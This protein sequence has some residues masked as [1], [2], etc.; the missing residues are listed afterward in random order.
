MFAKI[1]PITLL[2]VLVGCKGCQ[3][4][5]KETG[6]PIGETGDTDHTGDTGETGVLDEDG[7]GIPA[8][9]DCDDSDPM[10]GTG[11]TWYRD[12]DGDGYGGG[13]ET[14]TAC[15][16]PEGYAATGDDCD[17]ND[18]YYHPGATEDDCLDPNDYNCDGSVGYADLDGDGVPACED[19]DDSN[20]GANPDA[21]ET[22]D[23]VD[24]D[25]DSEIDEEATDASTWYTD[26]DADGYGVDE[27]A[28]TS[29]TQPEGTAAVTGD[30]DDADAAYNPG[31]TEDD[32]S[33]PNDYNC[34]G[35]VGYTDADGDGWAAC[36]EC[37]DADASE[38]PDVVEICDG[39]DDDCDGEIDEDDAYDASTWYADSDGDTYG[40]P[41]VSETSCLAPDGYVSDNTDCDDLS[42]T[43]F[44]G[45]AEECDGEDND[46]DEEIDE[47][48]TDATDWYADADGDTYGDASVSVSSCDPGDGYSADNTDCDDTNSTEYPGADEICD[49]DDDDC[50]GEIDEDDATDAST[51][52]ADGD[53]DGYGD[54]A[55]TT[56]S[57]STPDG[58][59]AY[60]GDCDDA[61]PAY[62]P[63]ATE[64]DC[65]DPNDY[66]CDGSVG[67]VDEDGDGFAACEECDDADAS[68]NPDGT[69]VCDDIDN[70]C[71]GSIDE[72]GAGGAGTWYA[73][74]DGDGYGDP[75]STVESCEAPEGYVADATD[76]DDTD[77]D[78]HPDGAEYC[79]GVDDDCDGETDEDAAF[80]ASTWYA[81]TDSD[82]YGDAGSTVSACS[83]PDGYVDDDTDCDDADADSHPDALEYCDDADNDCDGETDEDAEDA[84]KY[85]QDAD[86]DTY[87]DASV[88]T[89]AC[90]RPS[91]SWR[92][93]SGDCDD[94][95]SSINPAA[96]EVC[97]GEDNDCDGSI[98]EAGSSGSTTWHA[99][100]DGDG[101]GDPYVSE[102]SCEAPAGY[103]DDETDCD[104]DDA[105]INPAA[106]EICDGID[107]D[108][109]GSVDDGA[110]DSAT[111]YA[112]EDGD[113][114]GDASDSV[115]SCDAPSGYVSDDQDCDD[116]DGS[117]NPD[118]D[119]VCDGDDDDCDGSIDESDAIDES[120]W[121]YDGDDDGYG[122]D[123]TTRTSCDAP[124]GYVG[125]GGDC[126]DADPAYNPGAT[127]DDCTDPNDY[128]CDGSTGYANA[129]GDDY[130]ACEDCDDTDASEYPGANEICD[131]DDD[132]CDGRTDESDAV[133]ESTWYDDDDGD[134][135]G[136]PADSR[137]ACDAPTG[138]VADDEDCDD[139]DGTV[140]P[141]AAERCDDQDND[142][143]GTVDEGASD[144]STW[145]ADDDSD[146][147]GDADAS[148]TSCDAPT[149]YVSDDQDCDDSDPDENPDADEVCDG[150]DD[151]CDGNVDEASAVDASTWYADDDSDGYGDPSTTRRACD[152][153]SGYT[154]DDQDCDDT[155]AEV[156]PGERERC[157]D[158][159]DDCDG[160]IDESDAIDADTWYSDLDD[161][162]YGDPDSTTISCTTPD[163]AVGNDDDCDDGRADVNPGEDEVCD[164]R[165]NDCD[166]LVDEDAVD[167]ETWY[168]EDADDDGYG[169]D[170]SMVVD[171][172]APSG[173]VSL[174]GDCDD[175]DPTLNPGETDLCD[176]VDNDCDGELDE[177]VV[178]GR[179]LMSGDTS[180]DAVLSINPDDASAVEI[181]SLTTSTPISSVAVGP[182]GTAFVHNA[183]ILYSFDP[184]TG[185]LTEI[186]ASGRGTICG[187][188]FD[189]S[190]T[191][192]GLDRTSRTLVTFDT[193]TGAGT[194]VGALG[195]RIAACGMAYDCTTDRLVAADASTNS[196]FTIDP[197]SGA[198]SDFVSTGLS[199]G[200]VGLEYDPRSQSFLLS[201]GVSL[202]DVD[203][204]TGD[205][206]LIGTV[207]PGTNVD[208]LVFYPECPAD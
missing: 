145:Y 100:E 62:N 79:N 201:T 26:A 106:S 2:S 8:G 188:T 179:F 149:G 80:D 190:G 156:N 183:G 169:P 138:Y 27:G 147:F 124:S 13:T 17:D 109:D 197:S 35:S 53:S 68:I 39:D 97:D 45:R 69:E 125:T 42:A 83:Q 86:R 205:T 165:D 90:E 143:D 133:D 91:A 180:E 198:T 114:F 130:A 51:W 155:S 127:E 36:A 194:S 95:D 40:D 75:A 50:D 112:D 122:T 18:P 32:C 76:C 142:C 202:Y 5:D 7:D 191:L 157:N 24:N 171:C 25:C 129:D 174:G 10:V 196:L 74:S 19:C 189:D 63:G 72:S 192:Y 89:Y 12:V 116:S 173:S 111:W 181:T 70:D 22:C 43:A 117:E 121:Y 195:F 64:D 60:G 48:A 120:T 55:S 208:D 187:L 84:L 150:D 102:E 93:R 163:D 186:G 54:D 193:S 119:E 37:D 31:A 204:S 56:T 207:A 139:T 118:A 135:Y 123:D 184:C 148:T 81:D 9:E 132:D 199:L 23:G 65:A 30:C 11:S 164:D 170:D 49:G 15:E 47:D 88:V 178:E 4:K 166:D 58:Y 108:C 151:D 153:P 152:E 14:T 175:T 33:D 38:N 126:D 131:G 61:D 113:G 71:D 134:G 44:P 59:A 137:E 176:G 206:A 105:D 103:V 185:E 141:G 161:D 87:G 136:D 177:A 1:L 110:G 92:R 107:N 67:F 77:A 159:D 104:D 172:D 99:D 203:Y 115:A 16:E 101:Y 82:G 85:Y 200:S 128:N 21:V 146:G 57:C 41:T 94:T 167:A 29:C 6:D 28:V 34:D 52:Y 98:D 96:T 66:N 73:D 162:G 168:T 3:N 140:Y 182:D 154:D 158:I 160:S 20:P 46:C 144:A 78:I